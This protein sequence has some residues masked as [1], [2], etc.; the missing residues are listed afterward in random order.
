MFYQ[1]E[2]VDIPNVF[3][4]ADRQACAEKNILG[5]RMNSNYRAH[6]EMS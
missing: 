2:Y 3:V 6:R 5:F 1:E 4:G